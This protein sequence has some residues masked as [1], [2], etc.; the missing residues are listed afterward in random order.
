MCVSVFFYVA[1]CV[2]VC[3]WLCGSY[4]YYYHSIYA[5]IIKKNTTTTTSANS[6]KST[7]A[8]VCVCVEEWCC[9]MMADYE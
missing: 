4:Y 2:F 6:L 1:G 5:I 7:A 3:V 9:V 8:P